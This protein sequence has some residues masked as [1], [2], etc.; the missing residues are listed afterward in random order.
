MPG[1]TVATGEGNGGMNG[2]Q[3]RIRGFD[4]K[5]DVYVDGLRDFMAAK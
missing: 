4:A 1:I 5:G 3:F 2:D